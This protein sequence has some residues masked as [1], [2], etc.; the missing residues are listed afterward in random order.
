MPDLPFKFYSGYLQVPGA[1]RKIHYTFEQ[2]LHNDKKAPLLLWLNGGPGCSSMDGQ[3]SEVGYIYNPT[4]SNDGYRVNSWSWN[5]VAN[6]LYFETPVGVGFSQIGEDTDF[7]H[8]DT[9]TAEQNLA[10][11]LSFY[12]KFPEFRENKFYVAGESYAGVYIPYFAS[13]IS[14]HNDDPNTLPENKINFVGMAIG[15]GVTDMSVDASAAMYE[16]LTIRGVLSLSFLD[17]WNA[18]ECNSLFVGLY[19]KD[20]VFISMSNKQEEY[21]RECVRLYYEAEK[22]LEDVNVYGIN[23]KCNN[24]NNFMKDSLPCAW[25][26]MPGKYFNREDV[27]KALHVEDFLG[28]WNMCSDEVGDNYSRSLTGSVH[29]YPALIAKGYKIW[30]YSGDADAVVPFNGTQKW[31]S[32]LDLPLVTEWSQWKVLNNSVIAGFYQEYEG[33]TFLTVRNAGHMVPA[34]QPASAFEMISRF[35]NDEPLA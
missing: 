10:A 32:A 21:D 29:L 22:Q 33:L 7:V 16:F 17:E 19:R 18:R 30:K 24:A 25:S 26:N 3:F 5:R 8:T 2:H 11:L 35:L 27:K 9:L 13:E 12:E 4:D 31:I 20:G 34:N 28:T 1:G 6:M 23:L 15:N 14:L